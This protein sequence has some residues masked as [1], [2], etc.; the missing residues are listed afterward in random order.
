MKKAPITI[1]I[2]GDENVELIERL[3]QVT[4]LNAPNL[5][6]LLLRKYGK[7][8]EQ[9]VGHPFSSQSVPVPITSP[10]EKKPP[11][12]LPTNPGEGL[13]PMEL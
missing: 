5:V 6:A 1:T 11:L 10:E 3:C 2:M 7:D 13:T 4:G 8:L 9:W 12:E